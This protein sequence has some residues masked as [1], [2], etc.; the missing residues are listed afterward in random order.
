MKTIILS[1]LMMFTTL[2]LSATPSS[3]D[4]YVKTKNDILYY[5]RLTVGP[6]K[7]RLILDNGK[8]MTLMNNEVVAYK[9]NGKI[10]EKVPLYFK[11]KN[12]NRQVFMEIIK[13]KNGMK[14]Y[15]YNSYSSFR[16]GFS[17]DDPQPVEQYYVF[18]NGSYHLQLDK[19]NYKTVFDFFGIDA[20]LIQ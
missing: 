3:P 12:T 18:K 17:A 9:K 20:K 10:Y 2:V 11:D 4:E 8:K 13:Y 5:T 1:C 6:T 19:V 7:A 16:P 14:L 15:R